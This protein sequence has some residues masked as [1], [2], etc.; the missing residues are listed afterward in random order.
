MKKIFMKKSIASTIVVVSIVLAIVVIAFFIARPG[1]SDRGI[2]A[3]EGKLIADKIAHN[4]SEEA[5]LV[6]VR[7]S[8]EMT[9]GGYFL[10]WSYKYWD[11]KNDSDN[12]LG[13]K[14]YSDGR[15]TTRVTKLYDEQQITNWMLDSDEAYKIAKENNEIK[16]WLSKYRD[17]RVD[18]FMLT[19]SN[20]YIHW[21]SPGFMDQPHNANIILDA[22][23]GEVL[24]VSTQMD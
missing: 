7:D 5:I 16:K 2:T 20:W 8:S 23:T 9:K 19:G 17:A 6:Y 3:M 22:N 24:E 14:V 11:G 4:W 13:I 18:G 12:S 10:A 15:T 1:I 21:Y